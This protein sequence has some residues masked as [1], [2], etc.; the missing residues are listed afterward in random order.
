MEKK[1]LRLFVVSVL[2]IGM[3][4]QLIRAD[5]YYGMAN[6][7]LQ[8]GAGARSLAMGGAYVALAD[9]ASGA[10]WNPAAITQVDEHQFLSMYAPFFE[11]T[12]YNFLSYVHPLV[13]LGTLAISDVLVHSGG[14]DEVDDTGDVIGRNKLILKNAVIISYANKLHERIALGASLKLIH[15]RVMRYSGNGQGIDLGILYQPLDVLNIGLSLQNVLQPKVTLRYDPDVYDINLKAGMAL[16]T[17]SNRLTLTA[18]I[19]KLFRE[20][21][22]F[23]AGVEF[24]PWDKPT[25]ASLKR[26][27]L[28]LGCNHL[29]SFTC[30]L[31]LKIKFFTVD[32]AFSSHDL[33]NLHK[34]ALTFGWGNIYKASANPILKT[35]NTYGLD[36]LTNELEFSADI[37]SIIVKKWTLEI[38]DQDEE[39]VK[40]FSGET[41]PPEIIRWDVCDEMGRPV[42]R[43]DYVYEFSVVYKNDKQWVD[44]GEIKLQSF[45][46]EATPVEMEVSGE[47]LTEGGE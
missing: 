14:Y 42:K 20:K 47:E 2:I 27:D 17:F 37:P 9:E 34:F 28:R 43:G 13:R 1:V 15:Q 6:D 35:E 7:Y 25:S 22:Y 23:C 46:Q 41:R 24:S 40:S 26:V 8:Y 44:K 11:K 38:K 5:N 16:K 12:N 31:G 32:Y 29:Q 39:V 36:A 19:N 3:N 4:W 18:D 33:G 30:G 10:Y 21:A 45:P